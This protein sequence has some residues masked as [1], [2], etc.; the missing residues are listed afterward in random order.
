MSAD[1][2]QRAAAAPSSNHPA[3]PAYPVYQS[4]I[5]IQGAKLELDGAPWK[6]EAT[7]CAC[8]GKP[9]LPGDIAVRD[10]DRFGASFTDGPSLARRGSGAV[11]GACSALMNAKPLMALQHVV[12]TRDAVYPIR[13]DIHRAWFLLTPPEPPY[14]AVV[15]DTKQAHLIW[16][17]PPTL[18]NRLMIVRLGGRILRIRRPILERAL[19]DC[20][21]AADALNATRSGLGAVA[22]PATGAPIGAGGKVKAKA[23]SRK[24]EE[25]LR[26][27]FM[28]LGR[29]F[30]DPRQGVIRRELLVS[31]LAAPGTPVAAAIGRL[32][33]LGPGELW[34]LATLAKRKVEAPEKPAPLELNA[35]ALSPLD[36]LAPER[37]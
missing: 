25:G 2:D 9:I 8:C 35:E 31:P 23:K 28:R 30:D 5:A 27:P 4:D 29:E 10:K 11:C 7:G 20:Q 15:S 3:H 18:D 26:H 21:I 14:V 22:E 13:K 6:S 37:S 33:A 24:P 12:I 19:V 1:L 36:E 17:T 16:R 32:L 34:A